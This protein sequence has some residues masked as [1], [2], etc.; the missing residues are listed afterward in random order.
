MSAT[1][2]SKV[3]FILALLFA[4]ANAGK[5]SLPVSLER[6]ERGVQ[7]IN[8]RH[9]NAG[10]QRPLGGGEP[11]PNVP[12]FKLTGEDEQDLSSAIRVSANLRR[13]AGLV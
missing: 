6:N 9:E 3:A 12:P 2:T 13:Y 1:M 5:F 10:A 7:S 11:K 8:K 4:I